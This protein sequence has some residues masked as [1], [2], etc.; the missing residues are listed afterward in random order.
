MF[1]D[2]PRLEIYEEVQPDD[3]FAGEG[4]SF[5]QPPEDLR[6]LIEADELARLVANAVERVARHIGGHDHT[7]DYQALLEVLT[8]FYAIGVYGSDE[9]ASA[10]ADRRYPISFRS[11]E[12]EAA[13][14]RFRRDNRV[15]VE[16]CLCAVLQRVWS[17]RSDTDVEIEAARRVMNA[18]RA[19]SYALDF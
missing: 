14:R 17:C 8:H 1:L 4:R 12:P 3:T 19:D 15:A 5:Q 6:S 11:S 10:L 18:I 13:L 7:P 9:I 2:A 16:H